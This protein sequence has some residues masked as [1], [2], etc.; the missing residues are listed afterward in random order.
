MAK[1]VTR[2]E[3]KCKVCGEVYF[4]IIDMEH[5][6]TDCDNEYAEWL[7]EM[8]YVVGEFDRYDSPNFVP[9]PRKGTKWE[10]LDS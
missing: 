2:Y 3:H 7:D 5:I 6:C 4:D 10:A 8:G 1:E 9:K